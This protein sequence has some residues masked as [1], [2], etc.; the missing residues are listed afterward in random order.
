MQI[1]L[2]FVKMDLIQ[3]S[4]IFCGKLHVKSRT[5]NIHIRVGLGSKEVV[6]FHKPDVPYHSTYVVKVTYCSIF[7][8]P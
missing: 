3:I 5:C 1:P 2:H 8:I 7:D 6:F 4:G